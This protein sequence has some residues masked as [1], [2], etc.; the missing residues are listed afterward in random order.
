[1]SGA[2]WVIE[3]SRT[4]DHAASGAEYITANA[5]GRPSHKNCVSPLVLDHHALP[6]PLLEHDP[7]ISCAPQNTFIP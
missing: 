2:L 4:G 1:M 3:N 5:G 6:L 7:D